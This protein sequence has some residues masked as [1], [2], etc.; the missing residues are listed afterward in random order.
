MTGDRCHAKK[1]SPINYHGQLLIQPVPPVP[2]PPPPPPPLSP[3]TA[4]CLAAWSG[5]H[6][7]ECVEHCGEILKQLGSL[8][9]LCVVTWVIYM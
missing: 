1:G 9:E 2:P 4:T 5:L 6:V 8:C 7:A 3:S